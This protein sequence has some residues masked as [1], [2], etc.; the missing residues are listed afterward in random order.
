[1]LIAGRIVQFVVY[2]LLFAV[3]LHYFRHSWTCSINRTKGGDTLYNRTTPVIV[4]LP[5]AMCYSCN[6]VACYTSMYRCACSRPSWSDA[7][8]VERADQLNSKGRMWRRGA[9]V[10]RRTCDQEVVWS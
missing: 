10:E 2:S 8:A 3:Y 9:V 7:A 6:R 1:V 4:V 5:P